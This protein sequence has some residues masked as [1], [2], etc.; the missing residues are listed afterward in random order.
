M[1]VSSSKSKTGKS[2]LANKLS[3]AEKTGI[4]NIADSD[5]KANSQVW[6]KLE[7]QGIAERLK[8]IDVSGNKLKYLPREILSMS[9]LKTLNASRCNIQ[10]TYDMSSLPRLTTLNMDQNDLEETTL[11]QLPSTLIKLNIYNNHLINLP[12]YDILSNLINLIDINISGNRL[13]NCNGIGIL[14][15][16]ITINFDNNNIT[17]ISIDIGNCIKL[18]SI[19]LRN[20]Q[21]SGKNNNSTEQSIPEILFTDTQLDNIILSGNKMLSKSMLYNNFKGIDVFIERRKKSKD[22]NLAGGAASDSDNIF[23][24]LP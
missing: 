23:G 19:S 15:N 9:N 12:P 18:K 11:A 22:R 5:L 8:T 13:T 21:L 3:Q 24:D 2:A 10:R 16:I 6:E 14:I 17:E 20:N 7:T 1:G 4:L